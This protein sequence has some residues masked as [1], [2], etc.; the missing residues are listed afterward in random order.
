MANPEYPERDGFQ[1]TERVFINPLDGA[2]DPVAKRRI[3]ISNLFANHQLSIPDIVRVLD[4]EYA[5]VVNVLIEQGLICERRKNRREPVLVERRAFLHSRKA[6]A[7][8]P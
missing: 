3:T 4:E 7:V 2:L 6:V 8:R 1:V 5:R